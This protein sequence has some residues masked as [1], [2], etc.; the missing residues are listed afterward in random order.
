MIP[1]VCPCSC[2]T[3]D[4]FALYYHN[5]SGLPIYYSLNDL[6]LLLYKERSFQLLL[7]LHGLLFV[8]QALT[9]GFLV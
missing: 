5:H 6:N 9:V 8:L 4:D 3:L 2:V 7:L 1:L